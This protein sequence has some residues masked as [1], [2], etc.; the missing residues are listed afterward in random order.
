MLGTKLTLAGG[1][2]ETFR[3]DLRHAGVFGDGRFG[4]RFNGGYNRSDTYSR[5]RT[6]LGRHV[7]A[8]GVRTEPPTSRWARRARCARSTARRPIPSPATP[9][10]TATRSRTGTAPAGS[11]TTWTTA[12]SSR[13]TAAPRRCE[14]EI[15]V[16][17]IGRVQVLKAIKPYA[18]AA[19]AADRYNVFAYWHSRTSLDPQ[20]SLQ[21]GLPLEERS[22]IFHVEGQTNWNFQAG[23]RAGWSSARRVRNTKVN[24]CGTLMNLANDD[25]SDDLYSVYGQVEYKLVPQLRAGR[26]ASGSTTATCSTP[27]SRPRAPS[28][29]APTRTTRSA[30]SVNRAFQTPNYSEFF[31][32]VPVAAPTA[33]PRTL[34]GGIQTYYAARAGEHPA[35][36]ARRPHHHRQPAVGVLAGRRRRW[37]SATPTSTSRR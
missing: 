7:A 4:Y 9:S 26:R 15:F 23:A 37:R 25:R 18:R 32:Q 12:P 3:G 5:T 24:T 6:R 29:S 13:W 17:G 27:S 28:S 8:A 33:S 22:D 36:R 1:E 30:F 31:L 20:V 19:V 34:E 21:S 35:G 2:L 10:A 14:N 16:T 11:T